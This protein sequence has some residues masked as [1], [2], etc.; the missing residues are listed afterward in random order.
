[1]ILYYMHIFVPFFWRVIF[2]CDNSD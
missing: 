2:R 1:M